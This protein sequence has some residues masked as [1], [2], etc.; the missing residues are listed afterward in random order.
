DHQAPDQYYHR[1]NV[2]QAGHQGR[3]G[4]RHDHGR[5]FRVIHLQVR[6]AGS[7]TQQRNVDY[8]EADGDDPSG[9]VTEQGLEPAQAV[10]DRHRQA[11]DQQQA[12]EKAEQL[13]QQWPIRV[14]ALQSLHAGLHRR[15]MDNVEQ[16]D[17]GNHRRQEAVTDDV[18][19]GNA[20]ILH[21]QEGSGAH[22]RRHQLTIDRGGH[23]NGACLLLA[24]TH[25]LHHGYGEGPG[26]HGVGDGGAG[27]KPRHPRADH[28]GLGRTAT[29]MPQHRERELDEIVARAGLLQQRAEQYEQENE[30]GRDPQGNAE[31]PLGAE[32]LVIG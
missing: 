20:D 18:G 14:G 8:T 10:V 27:N 30:A 23:F 26:G 31:Y 19:V 29:I 6:V 15:E 28:G 11:H 3:A 24:E 17:I 22:H 7:Y 32:P 12:G 13:A 21:H 1:Q 5:S 9:S 4:L 2:M 25:A 16:R